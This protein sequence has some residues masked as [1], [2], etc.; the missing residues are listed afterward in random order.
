MWPHR[1]RHRGPTT[2]IKIEWRARPSV[3]TIHNLAF[4]GVLGYGA[5]D[6]L[7]IPRD[8]FASGALNHFGSVNLIFRRLLRTERWRWYLR[9]V[10]I[11]FG[12]AGLVVAPARLLLPPLPA[13][14]MLPALL[15]I[16]GLAL[17][18]FATLLFV[19]VMYSILRRKQLV[20]QVEEELR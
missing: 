16:G 2:P 17:A 15:G 4:Q 18:T 7:A 12:A 3:F 5:L 9:E 11:P 10:A 6:H 14:G 19:P 13:L 8:A 1:T 20:T